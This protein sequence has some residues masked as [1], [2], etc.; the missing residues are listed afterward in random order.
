[1]PDRTGFARLRLAIIA[2]IVAAM[3]IGIY[4][5]LAVY[6][7]SSPQFRPKQVPTSATTQQ[8]ASKA[9]ATVSP[10]S[11]NF[12]IEPPPVPSPR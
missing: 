8:A 5:L 12:S 6:R 3:C 1:M 7:W 10:T 9:G 2:A 4:V 11:P